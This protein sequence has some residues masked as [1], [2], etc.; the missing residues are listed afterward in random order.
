MNIFTNI[1]YDLHEWDNRFIACM[2]YI[3][4]HT[5]S[6]GILPRITRPSFHTLSLSFILFCPPYNKYGL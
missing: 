5:T 6:A 3:I 4:N 1:I 2:N